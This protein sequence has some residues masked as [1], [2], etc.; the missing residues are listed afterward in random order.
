VQ[1]DG[2]VPDLFREGQGII[3]NGKLDKSGEFVAEEVC[4]PNMMEIICHLNS[5]ECSQ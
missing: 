2:I 4:W 5:P 1:F 3:A